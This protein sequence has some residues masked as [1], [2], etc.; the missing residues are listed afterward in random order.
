MQN[1]PLA[2]VLSLFVDNFLRSKPA[3]V[4]TDTLVW[5]TQGATLPEKSFAP[6][7]VFIPLDIVNDMLTVGPGHSFLTSQ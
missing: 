7:S 5:R 4:E 6:K 2:T 3:P 1:P